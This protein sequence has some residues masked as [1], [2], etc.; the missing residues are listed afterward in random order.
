MR[1]K[2]STVQHAARLP[3]QQRRGQAVGCLLYRGSL[4]V[5]D[6]ANTM[7]KCTCVVC[8]QEYEDSKRGL[9]RHSVNCSALADARDK[10]QL[11][12]RERDRKQVLGRENNGP[13]F[14]P[15]ID[16]RAWA[17]GQRDGFTNN[18]PS[19]ARLPATSANAN[20][21]EHRELPHNC[22]LNDDNTTSK[23][24]PAVPGSPCPEQCG[25]ASP[26]DRE[27][28]HGSPSP[29]ASNEDGLGDQIEPEADVLAAASMVDQLPDPDTA[30]P[31]EV[32]ECP[33]DLVDITDELSV[34]QVVA[35][36]LH[37]QSHE[38]KQRFFVCMKVLSAISTRRKPQQPNPLNNSSIKTGQGHSR[39]LDQQSE[40]HDCNFDEELV[41][42]PPSNKALEGI[43][44][45]AVLKRPSPKVL[46]SAL[47]SMHLLANELHFLPEPPV[48]TE[49]GV[50]KQHDRVDFPWNGSFMERA[51]EVC[52]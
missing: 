8:G 52:I 6:D 43:P 11:K 20:T 3:P 42:I 47:C 45:I 9:A 51:F 17:Q 2:G 25:C 24:T 37:G 28:M 12:K 41:P 35:F 27:G 32:D 15:F 21:I 38:Y 34:D 30:G 19:A 10:E 31:P 22:A 7:T 4:L 48:N 23:G 13:L 29:P 49:G 5:S 46:S 26:Q 50:Q 18:A 44:P 36:L 33:F 39:Y 16:P 14:R 40:I 1:R